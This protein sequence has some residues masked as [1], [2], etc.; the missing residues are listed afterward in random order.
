[1]PRKVN[2][3][4]ISALFVPHLA[5]PEDNATKYR[6]Y[7][8]KSEYEVVEAPL[9]IEAMHH[10]NDESPYMIKPEA[11]TIKTILS[12]SELENK[13]EARFGINQ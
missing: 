11:K 13:G 5:R 9:A 10:C 1:M 3:N 12:S 4:E 7:S 8:S 6:I 2:I